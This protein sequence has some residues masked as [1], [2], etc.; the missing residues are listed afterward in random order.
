MSYQNQFREAYITRFAI[1]EYLLGNL[2]Y[3]KRLNWSAAYFLAQWEKNVGTYAAGTIHRFNEINHVQFCPSC[4]IGRIKQLVEIHPDM[5][6][7][8]SFRKAKGLPAYVIVDFLTADK[9]IMDQYETE[10][11]QTKETPAID[12]KGF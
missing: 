7:T 5:Q 10:P 4:N 6:L 11:E 1:P 9:A 8:L 3:Y 12:W 2:T